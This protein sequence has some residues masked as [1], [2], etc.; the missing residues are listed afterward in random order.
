MDLFTLTCI[1]IISV[2]IT[3]ISAAI[4]LELMLRIWNF[5]KYKVL[6]KEVTRFDFFDPE[7][8]SYIKW[9]DN[10]EKPMFYYYPI[11]L[12]FHN[13]KNTLP[14]VISNSYGFRCDEFDYIKNLS[15][16][17][18]KIILV[19]GSAAWGFGSSSNNTTIAGYLENYL[20]LNTNMKYK[21]INLAVVNQNQTQDIQLLNWL[22]PIIKP[23]IVIHY[24]GWNELIASFNIEDAKNVTKYDMIPVNEMLNWEPLKAGNNI[25][26]NFINSTKILIAQKLL[27]GKKIESFF[28]KSHLP[29]KRNFKD[30]V[31]LFSEI[32]ISNMY[33][34]KKISEAYECEFL[35]VIQPNIFRKRVL[36][37]SE[38]K[39]LEL[40]TD[41]RQTIGDKSD[42]DYLK[43]ESY[44]KI[45]KNK[46]SIN[47]INTKYLDLVDMFL[48][49]KEYIFYSLVHCRD[50]GYAKVAKKIYECL[51]VNFLNKKQ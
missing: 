38:K 24:G 15:S 50:E 34:M 18:K 29:S 26:K 27:I 11:G 51:R 39:A 23:D 6:Y 1:V 42:R 48:N 40:Y 14:K 25:I 19:G 7:Y 33:R 30:N 49:E 47:N 5:F 20:N 10:W 46:K 35:Q 2:I 28:K 44:F 37:D 31:E 16:N 8:H 4:A 3:L 43:K 13:I 9:T 22:L 21:V 12:R 36:T 32:F 17:I 41:F 45:V